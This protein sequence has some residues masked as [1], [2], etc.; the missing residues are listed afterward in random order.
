MPVTEA[1]DSCKATSQIARG[2]GRISKVNAIRVVVGVS[3]SRPT[4]GANSA[5]L[6]MMADRTTDAVIPTDS[7]NSQISGSPNMEVFQPY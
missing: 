7:A 6:N 5:K 2:F 1:K 3:L 4:N